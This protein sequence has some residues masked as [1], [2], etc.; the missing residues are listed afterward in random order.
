MNLKSCNWVFIKKKRPDFFHHTF[1]IWIM[2]FFIS[3]GNWVLILKAYL[4]YF[5][6]KGSLANRLLQV[7]VQGHHH[8]MS[9][10]EYVAVPESIFIVKL[11]LIKYKK[12]YNS[13]KPRS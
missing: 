1:P 3:S 6:K 10:T 5:A 12:L 11:H 2:K 8:L 9:S 7:S 13:W 4:S